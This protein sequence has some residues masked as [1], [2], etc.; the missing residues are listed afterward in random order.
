MLGCAGAL[1]RLT[2]EDAGEYA[3]AR[4]VAGGITVWSLAG[5]A[6]RLWPIA[7]AGAIVTVVGAHIVTTAPGVYYEQTS[8]VFIAP[9]GS[10]FQ[11]GAGG[12]VSTAAVIE[13]QLGDQGSLPLSVTATI[14]G[15]GIRNGV[16]VRLPNDGGQWATDFDQE[17]LDVEVVGGSETQVTA[18][19][20]AT[21]SE[22]R[23]LL[24]KD[25]TS[26][27]VRPDQMIS[28]GLSPPSAPVFYLRGSAL[29]AGITALALGLALTLTVL[30]M[31]DRWLSRRRGRLRQG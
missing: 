7:V 24:R 2:L 3:V 28:I 26:V 6:R 15:A 1:Q 29:R 11:S 27:G 5:T 30:V 14:V 4:G 17:D 22:I 9:N 20:N 21:L 8:A 19:M 25:Q 23:T 31:T 10:G 16:W 18:H 13:S 12:S